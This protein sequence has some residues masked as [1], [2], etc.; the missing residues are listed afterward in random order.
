MDPE[1]AALLRSLDQPEE[2]KVEEEEKV[3]EELAALLKSLDVNTANDNEN[4]DDENKDDENKDDENKN[5]ENKD[6]ENKEESK[7]E[8]EEKVDEDLAALLKSLDVDTANDNEN[9]NND[10]IIL[11][12]PLVPDAGAESVASLANL[13]DDNNIRLKPN[14][15]HYF[16][17]Y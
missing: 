3:D 12:N 4:K 17:V 1:L 16:K 9:K 2:I 13:G 5:D 15:A 11:D 8:E 10:D 6:D 7:V 14:C